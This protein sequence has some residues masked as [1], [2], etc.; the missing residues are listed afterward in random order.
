MLVAGTIHQVDCIEKNNVESYIVNL[1]NVSVE[2]KNINE[3][4]CISFTPKQEPEEALA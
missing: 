3:N 1:K 2:I 4:L